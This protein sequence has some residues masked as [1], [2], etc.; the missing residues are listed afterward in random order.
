MINSTSSPGDRQNKKEKD[1]VNTDKLA[2]WAFDRS[3]DRYLVYM[4]YLQLQSVNMHICFFNSVT[5]LEAKT[6]TEQRSIYCLREEISK[7]TNVDRYSLLRKFQHLNSRFTHI[8]RLDATRV[9]YATV[10]TRDVETALRAQQSTVACRLAA[11]TI[12][13]TNILGA[14]FQKRIRV[15]IRRNSTQQGRKLV[16][17]KDGDSSVAV[18]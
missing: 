15:R 6:T 14:L 2:S 12:A 18:Q 3:I 8:I 1:V 10:S 17:K 11:V 5:E 13:G 4:T 7:R 16:C 9:I